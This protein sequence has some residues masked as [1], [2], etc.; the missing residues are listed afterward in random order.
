MQAIVSYQSTRGLCTQKFAFGHSCPEMHAVT[1]MVDLTKFCQT[2]QMLMVLIVLVNFSQISQREISLGDLM[3]LTNFFAIFITA[4][5]S[6]YISIREQGEGQPQPPWLC[7]L[8]FDTLR[9]VEGVS[10]S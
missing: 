1:K 9:F 3:I 8:M 4:C 5:I 10:I 6:G 7:H 2:K